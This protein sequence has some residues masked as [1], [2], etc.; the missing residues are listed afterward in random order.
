[1]AAAL[2]VNWGRPEA[3][4]GSHRDCRHRYLGSRRAYLGNIGWIICSSLNLL[5]LIVRRLVTDSHINCG[6][7]RGAGPN[8]T[9]LH[10]A[11]FRRV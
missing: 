9:H 5:F 10:G 3:E 8:R 2:G 4:D 11:G 1:M 6:S 7:P